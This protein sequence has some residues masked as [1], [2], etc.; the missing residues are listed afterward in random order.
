MPS[1][2]QEL[3]LRATKMQTWRTGARGC[4]TNFGQL[5]R[6]AHRRAPLQ[7][8]MQ[9]S[10]AGTGAEPTQ[11]HPTPPG[12]GRRTTQLFVGGRRPTAHRGGPFPVPLEAK[13]QQSPKIYRYRRSTDPPPVAA[14]RAACS[15]AAAHFRLHA[16]QRT[17]RTKGHG[18]AGPPPPHPTPHPRSVIGAIHGQLR[19]CPRTAPRGAQQR[20]RTAP[21]RRTPPRTAPAGTRCCRGAGISRSREAKSRP[22]EALILN[23]F[24]SSRPARRGAEGCS[25]APRTAS[26]APGGHGRGPR[27]ED[28]RTR[29]VCRYRRAISQRGHTHPHGDTHS[30]TLRGCSVTSA[31]REGRKRKTGAGAAE[32][33]DPTPHRRCSRGERR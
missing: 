6:C 27:R 31:E 13:N 18:A 10:R 33:P 32:R 25:N 11:Q 20:P 9:H 22:A 21:H 5:H 12:P 19:R 29:R 7:R 14:R 30:S 28:T 4:E 15:H 23:F 24:F 3:T 17:A 16:A 2:Y 26:A 8:S 1:A